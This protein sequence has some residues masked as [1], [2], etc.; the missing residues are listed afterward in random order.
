MVEKRKKMHWELMEQLIREPGVMPA[1]VP[2]LA[3][4]ERMGLYRQ[5]VNIALPQSMAAAAYADLWREV[6]KRMARQ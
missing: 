2:F 4:I 5:P 6:K 1:L 3:D